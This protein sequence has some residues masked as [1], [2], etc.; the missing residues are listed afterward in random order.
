MSKIGMILVSHGEFAKAAL[1]SAEMIA[2]KQEDVFA[3]ALTVEKSLEQLEQELTDGFH[4]L[5][6]TCDEVVV[7]C[8]IFGGTPF[9][10]ISRCKLK[11]LKMTAF[12]GLSLPL[13]I[14][15]LLTRNSMEIDEVKS[16]L[17]EVHAQAL[18]EI[19]VELQDQDDD[20]MDL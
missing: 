11:G 6:K 4:E 3:Y 19:V 17:E 16:H 12:T 13:L 15:F 5:S 14:D 10:A 8:D 7:I 1:N 20:D 18:N 2:G 9:N